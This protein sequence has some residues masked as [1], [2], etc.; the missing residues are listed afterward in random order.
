MKQQVVGLGMHCPVSQLALGCLLCMWTPV[1]SLRVDQHASWVHPGLSSRQN[2]T[3]C[4]SG[5][6]SPHLKQPLPQG[7]LRPTSFPPH[8]EPQSNCHKPHL[9]AVQPQ[10]RA[11]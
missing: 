7:P 4:P 5:S 10:W 11:G 6:T 8:N 9:K 3:F 2:V 1:L